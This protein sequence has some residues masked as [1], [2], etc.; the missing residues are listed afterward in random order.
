MRDKG[1]RRDRGGTP[2]VQVSPM[3]IIVAVARALSDPPQQSPILGH[4]ALSQTTINPRPRPF[5]STIAP[6]GGK[7][8]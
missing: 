8:V 1:I 2:R 3:S 5:P 6:A 7:V 4:L